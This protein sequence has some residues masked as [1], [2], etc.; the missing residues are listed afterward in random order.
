[1]RDGYPR[2]SLKSVLMLG[3]QMVELLERMHEIGCVYV[4]ACV[5]AWLWECICVYLSLSLS[6]CVCGG[7]GGERESRCVDDDGLTN[8]SADVDA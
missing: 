6:L 5:C 3:P 2:L 1:M 8:G 7:G 4:R